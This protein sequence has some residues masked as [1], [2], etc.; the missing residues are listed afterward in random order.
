MNELLKLVE[1]QTKC[2]QIGIK[3]PLSKGPNYKNEG[4][5]IIE[6]SALI[7]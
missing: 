2:F 1:T 5:R 3:P 6:I 4:E 7:N